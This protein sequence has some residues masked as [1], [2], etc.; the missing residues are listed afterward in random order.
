MICA[1]V[2]VYTRM[3]ACVR[4]WSIQSLAQMHMRFCIEYCEDKLPSCWL[5]M[6]CVEQCSVRLDVRAWVAEKLHFPSTKIVW[7]YVWLAALMNG[8]VHLPEGPL[9]TLTQLERLNDTPNRTHSSSSSNGQR[10]L[11]TTKSWIT[12]FLCDIIDNRRKQNI[13]SKSLEQFKVG[14]E[15]VLGVQH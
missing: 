3:R 8:M 4:V 5:R 12:C 14:V 10:C 2:S 9:L 11:W 6:H 13:A 1:R 7:E 15:S